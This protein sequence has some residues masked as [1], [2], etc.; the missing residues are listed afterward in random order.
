M[1]PLEEMSDF[2]IY[3]LM[4]QLN[5]EKDVQLYLACFNEIRKRQ[6]NSEANMPSSATSTKHPSP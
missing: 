3:W 2:D 1:P 4:S 6:C 5:L